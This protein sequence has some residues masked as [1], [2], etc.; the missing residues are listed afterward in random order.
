M[1]IRSSDVFVAH[2]RADKQRARELTE[3]LRRAGLDPY[4][5]DDELLGGD[6]W[7]QVLP[8]AQ[9]RARATVVLVGATID[10]AYYQR[11]EV[12]TAIAQARVE[13]AVHPVIPIYL[14]G[15]PE[16]RVPYGLRVRHALRWGDL[17]VE[18]VAAE[19]ARA[20]R[21]IPLAPPPP[22]VHDGG[23]PGAHAHLHDALLSFTDEEWI[24][25]RTQLRRHRFELP[26][27][28]EPRRR[29]AE[30][31]VAQA[32]TGGRTRE[33]PKLLADARRVLCRPRGDTAAWI[34]N[35]RKRLGEIRVLGLVPGDQDV[36]LNLDDVYVEL[37]ITPRSPGV[38]PPSP[39]GRHGLVGPHEGR[40]ANARTL[41]EALDGLRGAWVR[42]GV[43]G[44]LVLGLPG[45]GKST[46]LQRTW[47]EVHDATPAPSGS[48]LRAPVL[49][50]CA[51][52][53]GLGVE[54]L[55]RGDLRALLEIE[56]T[57]A[58]YPGAAGAW[59]DAGGRPEAVFLDGL[60]ELRD[61]EDRRLFLAWLAE[62]MK[63][64]RGIPFVLTSRPAAWSR[65]EAEALGTAFHA[66]D[67]LALSQA[68]VDDY[69]GRWFRH[70][71]EREKVGCDD[72]E[73]ATA[74]SLADT[75]AAALL[76]ELH[77]RDP[78][79]AERIRGLTGNPL[80]LSTVC[81]VHRRFKLLPKG[82]GL[83]YRQ[84][85]E[86]LLRGRRE[87]GRPTF[88]LDEGVRLLRDLA[89]RMQEST[90]DASSPKEVPKAEL[91]AH[92]EEARED[93]ARLQDRPPGELLDDLARGCGVLVSPDGD[94]HQFVHL[95]VQEFLA[96]EAVRAQGRGAWLAERVADPRW[97]EPI[98]LGMADSATQREF[99]GALLSG[100]L[101][102]HEKLLLACRSEKDLEREPFRAL[103]DAS[104][105]RDAA[106]V[107]TV[108]RVFADKPPRWVI[109]AAEALCSHPD[110]EVQR[111]AHPLAGRVWVDPRR[112]PDRDGPFVGYVDDPRG[113]VQKGGELVPV[114]LGVGSRWRSAP[115]DLEWVWVPPGEF[116]M[117]AT[118]REGE[119]GFDPE[120]DDDEGP[121]HRVR[122]ERGFWMGRFPVTNAQYRRFVEGGGAQEP[123]CFRRPG[124]DAPDQPVT[125]V[126]WQDALTYTR[127][128]SGVA[129]GPV[130][131]PTEAQW[132]YAAR[133]A[134]GRPYP[135][136][137]EAP[138]IGRAWCRFLADAGV[139]VDGPAPVGGRPHG[140][141]P[142]G[143]E[144]QA[145]NMW[146]WC[147]D[148]YRPYAP[149]ATVDPG[150]AP[151]S[152]DT[153]RQEDDTPR[154]LRGGSWGFGPGGLRAA[155]RGGYHPR[156]RLEVIGFRVVCRSPEPR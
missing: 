92:L 136:G 108:L 100:P 150:P 70:A 46:L 11:E 51:T 12:A 28:R 52:A 82:R 62:E 109:A 146:E 40:Q 148:P 26:A 104:S 74:L 149:G 58:G 59:L 112:H 88:D 139:S 134:D 45:S 138:D 36:D 120:A 95:T 71:A 9:R 15:L 135:W 21:A 25:V 6:E 2:A 73:L 37:E 107:A 147:L 48:P 142:F 65:A 144:E 27:H 86:V 18:G 43:R 66:F 14:P 105:G 91:I 80:T 47:C 85:L 116:L 69:V 106:D 123:Q 84:C 133:G 31:V 132:E 50:R 154:V 72:D 131:L 20:V 34:R 29:E 24:F 155:V 61:A 60:D 117:G 8:E 5:D 41:S 89:F 55:G 137:P 115:L 4:L 153:V 32:V 156:V 67:L 152:A 13:G 119:P 90:D 127:W 141:G 39:G 94:L 98:L 99:L 53:Q 140:A 113:L 121:P 124:F 97:R 130:T 16:D 22:G 63:E 129:G 81:L 87:G 114:D 103:L 35:L 19:V 78:T 75:E 49:V 3:A 93:I 83:L 143:A 54:S 151:H 111:L 128:A 122:V 77:R 1:D 102:T 57:A 118:K 145:G 110:E 23:D 44:V 56:A 42:R 7:D 68:S 38:E 33:L 101:P 126:S 76:D 10:R 125:G 64:W 17:G 79:E 96:Y 30:A